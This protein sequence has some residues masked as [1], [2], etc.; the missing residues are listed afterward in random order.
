MKKKECS[1]C[2]IISEPDFVIKQK[3]YG[4]I[5]E[6]VCSLEC[7][8][9]YAHEKWAEATIFKCNSKEQQPAER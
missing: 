1:S 7:L 4:S 3:G 9:N 6:G 8:L 5:S 2:G